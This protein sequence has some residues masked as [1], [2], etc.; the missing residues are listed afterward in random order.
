MTDTL[1][2][3]HVEFVKKH[4]DKKH[5]SYNTFLRC[6][7]FWVVSGDFNKRQTCLCKTHENFNLKIRKMKSLTMIDENSS[8]D[9]I[10]SLC[11]NEV[12]EACLERTC[13]ECIS[14]EVKLNEE[15]D[16]T[17]P[18][19]Y[20]QWNTERVQVKVKGEDKMCTKTVK[21]LIQSSK[22]ELYR[23]F[24]SDTPKFM[25]HTANV[26]HQQD[27][28]T[29]T[30]QNLKNDELMIHMDFSENYACKYHNEIQSAH[31]GGL[32]PQV[33]IHTS[34]LYVRKD[35]EIKSHSCATISE[36]TRHDPSAIAA[37]LK[38]V[39]EFA[40]E[41][42]S[43]LKNVHIVSDGPTTQYR[44]KSMFQL[45]GSCISDMFGAET[46]H[47]HFTESGHGKSAADGVG[48][49]LKRTADKEVGMGKDIPNHTALIE[50][51]KKRCSLKVNIWQVET[52][53]IEKIVLPANVKSFKG[54]MKIH[55]ILYKRGLEYLDVRRLSCSTC[56]Q[57]PL[58][59]HYGLGS[60]PLLDRKHVEI[61]SKNDKRHSGDQMRIRTDR[62]RYK[63]VYD[64]SESNDS[65]EEETNYLC[66]I[67]AKENKNR[68]RK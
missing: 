58:C 1:K 22:T 4:P 59:S 19:I 44:N 53:D 36:N 29:L 17:S 30:K 15:I 11:C 35:D 25:Q 56:C 64:S 8:T 28:I 23:A 67:L 38:P 3:L 33:T 41:H 39:I 42:V 40:K 5:V 43:F 2:N 31:F 21:K 50:I 68:N 27:F 46:I 54:T 37:H 24:V 63:D 34:V 16:L 65:D 49:Y 52:A 62:V 7:P 66:E 61:T 60:I 9:V 57:E 55:E 26:R 6:R 45:I 20:E 13:D 10:K 48:G 14:K 32:K 12:S 47:W 51:L 18:V